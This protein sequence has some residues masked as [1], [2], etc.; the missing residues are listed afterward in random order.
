M[1]CQFLLSLLFTII[2]S[3][4]VSAD[5]V[6]REGNCNIQGLG[7]NNQVQLCCNCTIV[8]PAIAPK[9]PDVPPPVLSSTPPQ[10]NV[11]LRITL[12][13]GRDK[14]LEQLAE[15]FFVELGTSVSDVRFR[16]DMLI[17]GAIVRR[18]EVLQALQKGVLEVV[19]TSQ[20]PDALQREQRSSFKGVKVMH[21][22]GARSGKAWLLFNQQVWN[23]LPSDVQSVTP[24]I[25]RSYVASAPPES[26]P[27]PAGMVVCQCG[28]GEIVPLAA[29]PK[30]CSV[31]SIPT[32]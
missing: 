5:N 4:T 13:V 29:C 6:I 22:G 12:D 11:H 16:F 1:R 2:L 28:N 14:E 31:V 26:R 3:T 24:L 15:R 30:G 7:D 17:E 32:R 21:C 27:R 20:A 25:C 10:R 19:W 8:V 9:V 23:H 18:W